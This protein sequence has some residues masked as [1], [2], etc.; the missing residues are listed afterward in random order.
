MRDCVATYKKRNG[1]DTKTVTIVIGSLL[2]ALLVLSSIYMTVD[3][4]SPSEDIPVAETTPQTAPGEAQ[5]ATESTQSPAPS[6][7]SAV[8]AE[9]SPAAPAPAA[10]A[11]APAV[12]PAPAVSAEAPAVAPAPAQ[13]EP[14][15]TFAELLAAADPEAGA[16]AAKKCA[17]CHTFKKGEP[18]RVGPNLYGIVGRPVGK[19]EGFSYSSAMAGHGG[20][21]DYALLDCYL[22]DPKSCIPKNKM[23]FI[24]VKNN[25]ERANLIAYLRNFNDAPP[26]LPAP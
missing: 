7:A 5:K 20:T 19:N 23:A 11:K 9:A 4:L 22:K 12:T 26:P 18:K 25:V 15:K 24:G 13:A 14:E 21:W 2:A 8:P 17:V 10:P 6:E 1:M 3:Q 16:K